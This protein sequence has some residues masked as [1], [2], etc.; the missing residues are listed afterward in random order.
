MDT[1]IIKDPH[2]K[3]WLILFASL[4]LGIWVFQDILF[5]FAFGLFLA[6][7]FQPLAGRLESLKLSRHVASLLCLFLILALNIGFL[8]L[9]IPLI[10]SQF[11]N[12]VENAPDI[13]ERAQGA[14]DSLTRKLQSR[15]DDQEISYLKDMVY[16][17][18]DEALSWVGE[19]FSSLISGGALVFYLFSFFVR[20]T[21]FSVLHDQ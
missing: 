14:Y 19:T 16:N 8:V 1:V 11:L 18:H 12:L 7:L 5:P 10:Q 20:C 13:I 17:Y 4:A 21:F 9:V 6:Y 2:L 3:H 15:L